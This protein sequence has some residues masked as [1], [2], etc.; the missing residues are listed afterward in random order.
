MKWELIGSW[1]L[2]FNYLELFFLPEKAAIISSLER[3]VCTLVIHKKVNATLIPLGT[4]VCGFEI[5]VC[6][7]YNFEYVKKALIHF[8]DYMSTQSAMCAPWTH[9]CT[10]IF[11][12]ICL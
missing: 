12:Y 5:T 4:S 9:K 6:C 1:Y 11:M 10:Q 2:F 3:K 8:T 7:L